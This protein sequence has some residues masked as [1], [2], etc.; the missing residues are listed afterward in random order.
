MPALTVIIPH[1]RDEAALQLLL[2]SLRRQSTTFEYE[3]IVISNP[4]S[5]RAA[6]IVKDFPNVCHLN[7]IKIGVNR[8]R[9]RGIQQSQGM[10]LFF[11]DSDCVLE[12]QTLLQKHWDLHAANPTLTCIGGGYSCDSKQIV[13]LT[14]NYIQMRWL[15]QGR[16]KELNRYLIG[17]NFSCK[18]PQLSG[19]L[20][21]EEILYGCSETEFFVRLGADGQTYKLFDNLNVL[22]RSNLSRL[23][24]IKKIYRQGFGTCYVEKKYRIMLR[25]ENLNFHSVSSERDL[26][27]LKM[28]WTLRL[29]NK[30]FK[31]GFK[32]TA[33]RISS[34]RALCLVASETAI[35][36]ASQLLK[37]FKSWDFLL[38]N[39]PKG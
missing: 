26:Y 29:A 34:A 5:A 35:Y 19:Q 23:R 18:E 36:F 6:E 20:F 17:G 28:N 13:D 8:A 4:P 37:F 10:V 22:H 30:A 7:E 14:Y 9:N 33:P 3:A 24:L 32:G 11:L 39:F 27:V 21:D 31:L 12:D 15:Y 2:E 16:Q 25:D 1:H 38:R